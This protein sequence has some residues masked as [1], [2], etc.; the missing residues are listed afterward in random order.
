MFGTAAAAHRYHGILPDLGHR[1]HS[2]GGN[3]Q[4]IMEQ[5]DGH[6]DNLVAVST[7]SHAALDQLASATTEQYARITAALDNLAAASPSK[8]APRYTPKNTNPPP[9][10]RKARDGEADPHPPILR[11]K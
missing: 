7:N 3:A 4:G 5:L 1:S 10:H 11:Q 8:P 2:Q 9:P 6:F